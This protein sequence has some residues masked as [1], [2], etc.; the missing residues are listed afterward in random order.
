MNSSYPTSQ[1]NLH[2]EK[3]KNVAWTQPSPSGC[4]EVERVT[5]GSTARV[6]S[7]DRSV[8]AYDLGR[9]SAEGGQ[10]TAC[11]FATLQR[12]TRHRHHP[13]AML[14]P[15]AVYK[16]ILNSSVKF[17]CFVCP[18]VPI[19]PLVP[20]ICFACFFL[21]SVLKTFRVHPVSSAHRCIDTKA[22]VTARTSLTLSFPV[23]AGRELL[24][25]WRL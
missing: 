25:F 20:S 11:F 22:P 15:I 3:L 9:P 2:V 19:G 18:C 1:V 8:A 6:V 12:Q 4:W 10:S 14:A 24:G 5:W 23:E 16:T 17:Q 7:P 21:G 13:F